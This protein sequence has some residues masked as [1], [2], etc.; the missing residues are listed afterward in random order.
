MKRLINTACAFLLLVSAPAGKSVA[1]AE[2]QGRVV[3]VNGAE[4]HYREY[5]SGEPLLLLHGFGGC[6]DVWEPFLAALAAQYRIIVPDLRGH[7]RS[8]NPSNE[9][10]H[11]QSA[12]DVRELLDQLGVQ[13][14]R[15]MVISTGGMTLLHMATRYPDRVERMVLIGATTYFPE[16]A[17]QIMRD[18]TPD[19]LSPAERAY[20]ARC[21]GRGDA[22]VNTLIRQFHGF[23][24]SFEDMS[25]TPPHLARI[26]APTLIVHG[27][28]DEF[29]PIDIPVAMYRSI[30][31][32][33][34]W[35][36]P[37]GDHVPIYGAWAPEFLRISI[38]FLSRA[39]SRPAQ[40]SSR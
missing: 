10:T 25:F 24:D 13:R 29:F 16:Q 18:S 32:S 15:A 5:G 33:E 28:R 30:P 14:V 35:I 39:R 11:R 1:Q 7:G 36:V 2:P 22:Q 3:R 6:G 17:R 23:K 38:A 26:A 31:Q 19:R 27:D 21:A 9:F 37:S 40:S 4:I 20:F 34:L 8:T 12:E